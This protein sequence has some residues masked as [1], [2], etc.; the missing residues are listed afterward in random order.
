MSRNFEL[1]RKVQGSDPLDTFRV[2][3]ESWQEDNRRRLPPREPEYQPIHEPEW[4]RAATVLK[5]HWRPALLFGLAIF[6]LVA[7]ITFLT[8]SVYEPVARLEVDPPGTEAFSM[9]GYNVP[10]NATEYVTTQAK[11]LQSDELALAVLRTLHLDRDP[12]FAAK[13]AQ[14]NRD[15][16]DVQTAGEPQVTAAENQALK[17]LAKRTVVNR[18]SA[19]QV[20][21][22]AVGA[23]DPVQ[24][25]AITNTLVDKFVQREYEAR[26]DAVIQSSQWLQKQLDDIRARM[27]ESNRALAA[28]QK[29]SGLAVVG[30]NQ[31]SYS[32]QMTELSRQLMQSEADRIQLQAYLNRFDGDSSS[33]LPQISSNPV[34]QSLTQKLAEVRADITQNLAIYG[35]N[36]PVV[37]KLQMQADELQ[38][39]L[40]AQRSAILKD[41]RTSYSAAQAREKL[42]QSQLNDANR[43][44]T[45]MTQYAA[46]KKEADANTQLYN[47]LFARIKESGIAAES[48]SSPIRIVDRARVLDSPTRPHRL[49][50]LAIGLL[51]GILGGVV[52]AFLIEGFTT[53]LS[54]IEDVRRCIGACPVS[55]MPVIDV[56]TNRSPVRRLTG[57]G[58][59]DRFSQPF[60]INRPNSPEAEALR[61]LYTAVR[62][63][64]HN[65]S[66]HVILVASPNQGEG[67]TLMSVNL[68]LALAERGRTCIVDADLRKEGVARAFGVVTDRGLT[69]VLQGEMRIEEVL[70]P[71]VGVPNLTLLPTGSL[72]ADAARFIA[73]SAMSQVIQYLR[74]H[75]DFVLIDSPPILPFSDGRVL[76]TMV[77]GVL[78]VGRSGVTKREALRRSLDLLRE[79]RSAPVIQIVLNAVEVSAVEY[80]SYYRYGNQKTKG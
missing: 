79:I 30:D 70:V 6:A 19:S 69:D 27:Q 40:A 54:T 43:Q 58:R 31:S 21:D 1:L 29:D 28:F 47:N 51:G 34:V 74:T 15:E 61:G 22:V 25:A 76:A 4:L 26:H 38:S 52:L 49:R 63:S 12:D 11:N 75:F 80:R 3:G 23:H 24:A 17:T 78:L 7:V 33:S 72:C 65:Q 55:V 59:G 2:A 35:K 9:Q 60:L 46:L 41:L 16:S 20:I 77:D 67:K 13:N 37:K 68:A 56:D 57:P 53:T 5:K 18:D 50:N 48:K 32:E 71:S 36:H 44:L 42:M 73:S 14:T 10:G 8:K 66:A 64:Q 45:L 62:L 39:Q